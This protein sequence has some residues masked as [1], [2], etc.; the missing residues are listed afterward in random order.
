MGFEEGEDGIGYL[1]VENNS[2]STEVKI[3]LNFSRKNHIELQAPYTGQNNPVIICSPNSYE[4]LY[5]FGTDMPFGAAFSISSQFSKNV[6]NVR[7]EV[8]AKGKRF[9][10]QD[11]DGNDVGISVNVLNHSDGC[12]YEFVNQSRDQVLEEIVE[13]ELE[14]CRIEGMPGNGA[15]IYLRPGQEKS[16]SIKQIPG[17]PK[18]F[19]KV[20]RMDYV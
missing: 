6:Q 8:R 1:Y 20:K 2:R 18:F 4:V 5:Y 9:A 14:N 17:R 7:N 15:R 10:R 12:V 19:H 13:F 16:I 11:N 3:S